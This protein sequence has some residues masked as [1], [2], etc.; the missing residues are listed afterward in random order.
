MIL[1]AVF[2]EE[3]ADIVVS[4]ST[5]KAV[6]LAANCKDVYFQHMFRAKGKIYNIR[7]Y[8]IMKHELVCRDHNH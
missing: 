4:V 8:K 2:A 5:A 7:N 3:K 1:L 6:Q